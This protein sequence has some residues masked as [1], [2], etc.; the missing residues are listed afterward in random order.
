M[1]IFVVIVLI[2]AWW[3]WRAPGPG[4]GDV[5]APPPQESASAPA[6]AG[7]LLPASLEALWA[8]PAPEVDDPVVHCRLAS[9][10]TFLRRSACE[11]AGGAPD[12]PVWARLD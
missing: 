2:I 8:E 9:G 4:T 7:G 3:V 11:V 5:S 1:R 12:E 10:D 6:E